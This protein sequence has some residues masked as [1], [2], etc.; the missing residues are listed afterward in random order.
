MNC[1]DKFEYFFVNEKRI[2][3]D[4]RQRELLTE[5][6]MKRS[7]FSMKKKGINR[8]QNKLQYFLP[9]DGTRDINRTCNISRY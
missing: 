5:H 7:F 1:T 2:R 9:E 3:R 6:A 4:H 8:R